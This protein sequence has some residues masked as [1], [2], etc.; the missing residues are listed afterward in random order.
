MVGSADS[1]NLAIAAGLV[2]YEAFRQHAPLEP[3]GYVE[4]GAFH[5]SSR[6]R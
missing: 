5:H 1:L 3:P 2:L 6:R 4:A